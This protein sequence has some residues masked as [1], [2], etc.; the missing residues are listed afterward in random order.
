VSD[1]ARPASPCVWWP[2]DD[3]RALRIEI[4]AGPVF[5][6]PDLRATTDG[7]WE[8]IRAA[9]PRAFNGPILAYT[10]SNPRTN[11]VR[12]RRDEYRRLA[13][14]PEIETGVVHLGVTGVLEAR[15]E[16]GVP[17]VLLGLRSH[18]TRI[19]GGMWELGPSGGVDPPPI[20]QTAMDADDVW[21]VL[22]NEIREE[23]G[24]PVDPD[25]SPPMGLLHDPVGRSCELV[26]RVALRR[27]VEELIALID[28]E[29]RTSRWEYDAVRWVAI[30]ELEAFTRREPSIP[31]LV[32]LAEVLV[33]TGG[34]GG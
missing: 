1:R 8:R 11:L 20:D 22:I 10:S 30:D 5:E 33:G 6:H 13:V 31:T 26:V 34:R 3:G 4:D 16:S 15:D 29:N 32:A 27:P 25:P 23:V 18:A 28:R 12:C 24:L 2:L 14:T 7:A 17:H 21:R 9:N 19:F